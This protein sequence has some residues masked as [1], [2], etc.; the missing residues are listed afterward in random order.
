MK[1]IEKRQECS[2]KGDTRSAGL[3]GHGEIKPDYPLIEKDEV[4]QA[5][6]R[7]RRALKKHG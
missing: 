7:I 5:E 1:K 3:N 4:K 6:E 2:P